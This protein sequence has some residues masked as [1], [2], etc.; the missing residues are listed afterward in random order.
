MPFATDDEVTDIDAYLSNTSYFECREI[1][2]AWVGKHKGWMIEENSYGTVYTKTL[3]C[4]RCPTIRTDIC[5]ASLEFVTRHYTYPDDYQVKGVTLSRDV[6]RRWGFEHMS[7][8]ART[9]RK[10]AA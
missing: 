9:R 3:K 4:M 7:Q 6:V 1:G 2:H 10:R 5:N 8:P